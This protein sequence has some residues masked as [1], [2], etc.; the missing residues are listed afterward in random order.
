MNKGVYNGL[1]SGWQPKYL[2]CSYIL[3]TSSVGKEIELKGKLILF[4]KTASAEPARNGV[5]CEV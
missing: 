1:N 2:H 5:T 4:G 3:T